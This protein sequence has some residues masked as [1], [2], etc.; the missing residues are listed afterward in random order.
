LFVFPFS[1]GRE[2]SRR[3]GPDFGSGKKLWQPRRRQ[4]VSGQVTRVRSVTKRLVRRDA[5]SRRRRQRGERSWP[6]R[7]VWRSR[8]SW[9][10]SVFFRAVCE[11]FTD[12]VAETER[13]QYW[14]I[15]AFS[16]SR[17]A[18]ATDQVVE[19]ARFPTVLSSG[20]CRRFET[21]SPGIRKLRKNVFVSAH[22]S[23]M[24]SCF[25]KSVSNQA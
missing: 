23:R 7:K 11:V 14:K 12:V 20:V 17:A 15:F 3:C 21:P 4:M 18:F 24:K 5:V 22:R 9:L 19:C 8:N 13:K 25:L 1:R 2:A 6:L 10:V 16:R